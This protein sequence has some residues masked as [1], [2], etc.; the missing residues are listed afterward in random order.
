[1]LLFALGASNLSYAGWTIHWKKTT[2]TPCPADAK[3]P[4]YTTESCWFCETPNYPLTTTVTTGAT[5]SEN[6]G[7]ISLRVVIKKRE[8]SGE[9]LSELKKSQFKVSMEPFRL[10]RKICKAMRIN[11]RYTGFKIPGGPV[12][13]WEGKNGDLILTASL[14]RP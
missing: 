12:Y 2:P 5:I 4:C 14:T 13:C 9:V 1:M 6:R 11:A 7:V 3:P 10:D 8:L